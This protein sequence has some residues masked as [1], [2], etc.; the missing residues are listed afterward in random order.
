VSV[1]KGSTFDPTVVAEL[2]T[3]LVTVPWADPA[4]MS[5][6]LDPVTAGTHTV[7]EPGKRRRQQQDYRAIIN[8]GT[9]E[10]WD[11]MS[12]QAA[13]SVKLTA[14]SQLAISLG[15]RC[16]NEYSYKFFASLWQV[17]CHTPTQLATQDSGTKYIMLQHVKSCFNGHRSGA[18][19]PATWVST[20]PDNL[21]EFVRSH[22]AVFAAVFPG[23]S[24]PVPAAIDMTALV[25]Y[26]N[27]YRCRGGAGAVPM[28]PVAPSVVQQ[29]IATPPANVMERF[30]STL[31]ANMEHMQQSQNRML[32]MFMS[33]SGAARQNTHRGLPRAFSLLEDRA[34]L[35]ITTPLPTQRALPAL[36]SGPTV[37]SV[38][39]ESQ[40]SALVPIPSTP[41]PSTPMTPTVG[42]A[43]PKC[44][45]PASSPVT[46]VAPV[47]H[48]V[49]IGSPQPISAPMGDPPVSIA[50]TLPTTS[51]S[52]GSV[53]DM[54]DMLLTRRGQ[55]VVRKKPAAAVVGDSGGGDGAK[56]PG[57]GAKATA[58]GSGAKSKSSGS[59]DANPTFLVDSPGGCSK[60]RW[61]GCGK[62]QP[63]RFQ[64]KPGP[65][66]KAKATKATKNT[67]GTKGK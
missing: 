20:L 34:N 58:S 19:D 32:D 26:D 57:R 15:C 4:H 62:C 63:W 6:V 36:A 50:T 30:A 60:C 46:G 11:L 42:I 45:S 40:M 18:P 64:P 56:K 44:A 16:P 43:T 8:Y 23:S 21:V 65:K 29:S 67:K 25:S 5:R 3:M 41:V 24:A 39:D 13:P 12:S 35:A 27:S 17:V 52:T 47:T 55:G 7:L 22:P 9:A 54:L 49:S 1:I 33:T 10:F 53:D 61:R 37:E 66:A 59:G 14:I 28:T 48:V 31:V 51:S 38:T 2:S